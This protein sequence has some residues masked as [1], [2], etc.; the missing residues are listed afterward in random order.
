LHSVI[1]VLDRMIPDYPQECLAVD[2]EALRRGAEVAG[3]NHP[4]PGEKKKDLIL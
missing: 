3:I 1:T 2:A 4:R